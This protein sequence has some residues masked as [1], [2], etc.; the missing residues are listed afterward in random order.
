MTIPG[1]IVGATIRNA[2]LSEDRTR[3]A[4]GTAAPAKDRC[5]VSVALLTA[6]LDAP[7]K[8]AEP[9]LRKL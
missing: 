1:P 6:L 9:V 5:R 3:A 8:V 4:M 7:K 2:G